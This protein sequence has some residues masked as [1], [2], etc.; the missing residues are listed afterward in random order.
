VCRPAMGGCSGSGSG[1]GSG[2][3]PESLTR[4]AYCVARA[5]SGSWGFLGLGGSWGFGVLSLGGLESGFTR[6]K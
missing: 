4:G 6:Y 3:D 5:S 1:S 2:S